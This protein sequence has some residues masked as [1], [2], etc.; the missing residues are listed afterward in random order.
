MLI[1]T[2]RSIETSD[3]VNF[4]NYL[5]K[6]IGSEEVVKIRRLTFLIYD[7]AQ[8]DT[9]I[10]SGRKGE[11]LNLK[12]SDIDVMI[13]E[14]SMKVYESETDVV[15]EKKVA[16]FIMNTDDTQPCFTQLYLLTHH[17]NYTLKVSEL[18]LNMLQKNQLGSVL[19]S[20]QYKLFK[21]S[22]FE[23]SHNSKIHGP[24][25]TDGD[26]N[27]DCAFC[28]KCDTWIFQAQP[29]VSRPRTA[30]P[31]PELISKIISCG[32]LFVPIGYKGSINENIEWRISFSVAEK[33]LIF[34]FSHTQLLCYA[35]LKILLKEIVDKHEDLKGLLCSYFLKTLM[36]W[37]SEETDPYAWR[38]DN[39][40]P[41]FMA[42]L[43]R[44]LYCV[45]YSILSHYFIPG[46]NLF[47]LRFNTHNKYKL[48]TILMNLYGEGINCFASTDTLQDQQYQSYE[49]KMSLNSDNN[50][51]LQQLMPTFCF[52]R[53][54][55]YDNRVNR[56]W[57]LF[58]DFSHH[59]KTNLSSGLFALQLS[60]SFMLVP[61]ASQYP[62]ISGNKCHYVRYKH[63]LSHLMIGL[64]S[65]TVSGLLMLASF[66]YVH[67]KYLSSLTVIAYTL[68]K[69]MA[70]NIYLGLFNNSKLDP[71][72]QHVMRLVKREKLH[73]ILKS[74][75]IYSFRLEHN[76]SI[77]PQELQQD[78]QRRGT[79]FHPLPYAHF[80]S[81]LCH[82]HRHDITSY[83][84][85]LQQLVYVEWIISDCRTFVSRPDSINSVIMC[86][87][88]HLTLGES[89]PARRAFECA[90]R[91]DKYNETS[92]AS[93]LFSFIGC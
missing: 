93:R 57:K 5:C 15:I 6:K 36:F 18:L 60:A 70:E 92:A 61:E 68:K 38:P 77:V 63:D 74:L 89:Y 86:G 34:S 8:S 25:V 39:L 17:Q 30:W 76:S 65:D 22:K 3:S 49:I 41:C 64:H 75:T 20:E 7:I 27:Y 84:Q 51:Y 33:I 54:V 62:K 12:G 50:I 56:F 35:M 80:L 47:F 46:N 40:I 53:N 66:F 55:C 87:I 43:K 72:K 11:G 2:D 42:C 78:V 91:L 73:T 13:V 14:K 59:S 24:C 4:Y 26:D 85:S 52:L 81:F 88:A 10:S 31:S 69:C 16:A 79:I 90:A 37:I 45:R 9:F 58:Y 82:Y 83:Q 1:M 48:T 21:M 71:I 32:V 44:L 23:A 29:W 67:K 19:S 28:L